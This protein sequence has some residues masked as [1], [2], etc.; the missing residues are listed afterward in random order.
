MLF[1][2]VPLSALAFDVN[3]I[4]EPK[5]DAGLN[6]VS[7]INNVFKFVWPIVVAVIIISFIIAGFK[8]LSAQGNPQQ[9]AEAR[10]A[11]IWG[12]AGVVVI[13]LAYS[14]ISIV[15]NAFSLS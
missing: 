9:L 12:I 4:A 3:T 8:F 2:A 6:V 15:R 14:I 13:I 11:L 7:F 10:T 5:T 1:L